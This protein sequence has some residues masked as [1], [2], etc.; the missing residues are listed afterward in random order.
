MFEEKNNG[1]LIAK[2]N[3]QELAMRNILLGKTI[4]GSLQRSNFQTYLQPS[5]FTVTKKTSV[6]MP[7]FLPTLITV[8]KKTK[9]Q[10]VCF[11]LVHGIYT[12]YLWKI[13]RSSVI[14][15]LPLFNETFNN[16]SVI[17][18]QSV[19]LVEETGGPGENHR[20]VVSH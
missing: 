19:L 10:R 9:Y 4:D 13:V 7:P 1:K 18:W 14:L 17:S 5:I 3:L 8:C 12:K 6:H 11:G 2:N 16:F 15:L 20:P